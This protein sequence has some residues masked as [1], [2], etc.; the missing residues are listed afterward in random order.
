MAANAQPPFTDGQTWGCL[1]VLHNTARVEKP[2]LVDFRRQCAAAFP[3]H[4]AEGALPPDWLK[5]PGG[6]VWPTSYS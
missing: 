2:L 5:S 1:T 6:V 4:A 3:R